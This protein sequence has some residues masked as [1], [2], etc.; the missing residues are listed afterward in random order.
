MTTTQHITLP[1]TGLDCIDCARALEGGVGQLEGVQSATLN[2]A[3]SSLAVEYDPH[4]TDVAGVV[5]RIRQLGYDISRGQELVF[6]LQGLDCADCADKLQQA[7][8]ALPQVLEAQVVFATAQMRVQ[9]VP[10]DGLEPA[11]V[12]RAAE[13]GYTARPQAKAGKAQPEAGRRWRTRLSEQRRTLLTVVAVAFLGL[14][15]LMRILGVEGLA[16]N[17]AY[18]MAILSGGI[19]VARSGWAVLRTTHSLDMN[20]LM[21]IAAI[22]AVAIGEW[23]EGATAMVLFA[24]GNTL[25]AMTMDRSRQAIRTTTTRTVCQ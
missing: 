5:A 23:A 24:V 15:S 6:D 1:I 18:T 9:G 16:P 20:A 19:Y 21:T 13:L 10:G 12:K 3:A 17:V 22:G 25:E 8:A 11:I 7:I 14:A 2:F 4:F